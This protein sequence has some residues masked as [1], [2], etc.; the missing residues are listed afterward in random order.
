MNHPNTKPAPANFARNLVQPS[1]HERGSGLVKGSYGCKN[2]PQP[3]DDDADFE[4]EFVYGEKDSEVN[5]ER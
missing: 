1:A 2:R 3:K 4:P 5:D